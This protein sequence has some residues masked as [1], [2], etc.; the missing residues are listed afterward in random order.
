MSL[1]LTKLMNGHRSDE[2]RDTL[3]LAGGAA[4]VVLGAGL[5][6]ATPAIRRLLGEVSIG[7]L[8]GGAVPKDFQ[9]YLRLR[10]M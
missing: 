9:R 5:I 10:A 7:N 1:E 2:G 4:L 8:I 6:L 3:L